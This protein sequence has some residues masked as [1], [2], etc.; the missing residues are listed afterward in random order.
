MFFI[1]ASYVRS[2]KV[3]VR[4]LGVIFLSAVLIAI[5]DL[6]KATASTAFLSETLVDILPATDRASRALGIGG[7]WTRLHFSLSIYFLMD[8]VLIGVC[9]LI[10]T[11]K[12][13]KWI[14]YA[15]LGLFIVVLGMSGN[16]AAWIS[17]ATG[18]LVVLLLEKGIRIRWVPILVLFLVLLFSQELVISRIT[19]TFQPQDTSWGRV[20]EL[21]NTT[22]P[23]IASHPFGSGTGSMS[24]SNSAIWIDSSD[25]TQFAL[26]GGLLHSGYGLVGVETGAIGLVVFCCL[27]C[28][29]I[30]VGIRIYHTLDD[31]LLKSLS[32]GIVAEVIAFAVFNN[33]APGYIMSIY[34]FYFWLF[35]G[36]LIALPRIEARSI[37]QAS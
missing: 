5:W 35:A 36:L 19:D 31:K 27:L 7:S 30:A 16:R 32:L 28:S 18:L 11:M 24:A 3:L 15:V 9:L 33:S 22:L 37:M 34:N 1:L 23:F 4:I 20:D 6:F 17:L 29:H 12:A 14:L 10:R 2:R 21:L 8:I 25:P 13:S 26:Q